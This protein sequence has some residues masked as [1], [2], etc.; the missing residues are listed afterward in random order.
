MSTASV[1]KAM[2]LTH[3][4][5]GVFVAPAILFF[6]LTGALQTFSLHEPGKGTPYKPAASY[7]PAQWIV[8]L[9][10][11]HKNQTPVVNKPKPPAPKAV[12]HAN[13]KSQAP[14]SVASPAPP[15]VAPHN[16]MPL[17]YFFLLVAIS[18]F[19][20]TFSGIYMAYKYSRNRIAITALLILGAVIPVLMTVL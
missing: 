14:V 15:P 6:A 13:E 16:P 19:V 17:K 3:L 18:L 10:Q 8:I 11:I 4:Y 1:L 12:D 5:I 9:G 20:S 7:K 2:R